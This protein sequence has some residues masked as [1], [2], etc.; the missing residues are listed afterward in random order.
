MGPHF[1]TVYCLFMGLPRDLAEWTEDQLEAALKLMTGKYKGFMSC[2][3][4]SEDMVW[5]VSVQQSERSE[6]WS[7]HHYDRHMAL[8]E[9][10]GRLWSE[11][12][13]EPSG[14]WTPPR[15]RLTAQAVTAHVSE[16]YKDPEDLDPEEVLSVYQDRQNKE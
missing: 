5:E 3:Y 10:Y 6:P 9:A 1:P 14:K 7:V 4:S 12:Q 2:E 13:Q 11:S 16:K 15:D 8:Y